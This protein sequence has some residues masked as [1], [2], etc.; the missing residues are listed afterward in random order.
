MGSDRDFLER[1]VKNFKK[2]R[3]LDLRDALGIEKFY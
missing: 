3:P 1:R 2:A